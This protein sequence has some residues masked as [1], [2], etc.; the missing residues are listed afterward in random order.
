MG[1]DLPVDR[2]P[3]RQGDR[4]RDQGRDGQRAGEA[5]AL[6]TGLVVQVPPFINEGDRIRVN[7]ETGEYQSRAKKGW[8]P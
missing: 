5:R 8:D 3:A 6:E 1:I 2:R 7:T 4:A